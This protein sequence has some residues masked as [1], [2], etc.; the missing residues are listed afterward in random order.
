MKQLAKIWHTA[1]VEGK[2][3]MAEVNRHIQMCKA[4]PHP[5]TGKSP[6]E[7]MFENRKY[8]TRLPHLQKDP[9]PFIIEAREMK[10]S[11]KINKSDTKI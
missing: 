11:R 5:T 2:Y 10:K 3:P 7:M 6:A 1:L 9:S 8:K 4:N